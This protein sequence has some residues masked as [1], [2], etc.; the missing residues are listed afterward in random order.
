M[1]MKFRLLI[2]LMV[3]AGSSVVAQEKMAPK[4][5]FAEAIEAYEKADRES[6]PPS[7]SILFVGS[8]IFRLWKGLKEQMAPLP[9]F[10]RAFGGSQTHEIL[11]YMDRIVL[12]Y[13]PRIIVYY[14]GSNDINANVT[15]VQIAGNF[16]EFVERVRKELPETRVFF[17]S[18]NKA[19]Q[20]MD[21]WAQVD[22]A[23]GLVRE[24]CAKGRGLGY[25][26]VNPALF[27]SKGEPRMELYLPDRLHFLDPAYDEF[28]K[29]VKPVLTSA[30]AAALAGVK[31]GVK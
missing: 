31:A 27:D 18:I 6:P 29:I 20:K 3:M 8:S 17:V 26:D 7:R 25:I 5:R 24:Y 13:K 22:E 23:N 1:R 14:C 19:P 9:V 16:R 15:P 30:W 21:R 11:A 28:T 10:N 4:I 12:P 2:L